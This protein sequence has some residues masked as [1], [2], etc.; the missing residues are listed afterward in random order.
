MLQLVDEALESF[1][2]SRLG[3]DHGAL[4]VS[5]AAPDAEWAATLSKPTLSFYL[6]DVR[7]SEEHASAGMELVE[8]DGVQYRRQPPPR[9]SLSYL[10]TA[11]A[12][13]DRD[14]HQL[15]GS[16]LHAFLVAGDLPAEVLPA[17]LAEVQPGPSFT[18][19]APRADGRADFWSALGGQYKPGLDLVVTAAVD[20]GL[21]PPA[22]PPTERVTLTVGDRRAPARTSTRTRVGGKA[23]A[24]VDVPL[25]RTTRGAAVVGDGGRF[26]VPAETGDDV[27]GESDPPRR[28]RVAE[29]APIELD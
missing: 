8:R 6:W 7:P 15:L 19:A 18:L 28:G 4:D 13:D 21:G 12:A 3:F 22:G 14:E 20:P 17:P 25:V 2:R 26:L 16:L 9:I 5:F 23:P 24:G 11:W 29:Q 27:V 10:L 1:A